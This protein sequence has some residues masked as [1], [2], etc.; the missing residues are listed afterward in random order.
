[1][2]RSRW[3]GFLDG[4]NCFDHGFFNLSRRE[5]RWVDPQQR[6]LLELVWESLETSGYRPDQLA[7]E[8]TGVF[9]GVSGDEYLH[10]LAARGEHLDP[11]AGSG[12]SLSMLANRISYLCGFQG[13]SLALDTACSSSLVAVHLAC[14]SLLNGDADTAIAGGV[15]IILT[16]GGTIVCSQA[17]MLAADG[18]C[19]TFDN[20]A[21]G[22]V[23]SE[24]A[25]VI[26]LKPLAHAR[27]D[28]DDVW[29]VIKGSAVNHDGHSK[30]GITAPNPKAQQT[31]LNEAYR[32]ANVKPETIGY[33]E[34]HGTGTSLGDPLEIQGLGGVFSRSA[35]CRGHC[36]IGS[37]K[38]NI[39]HLEPAAGI[40]GLIKCVLALR[41]KQ[42]APT[43]HFRVP[44]Q[45]VRFEQ[46]AFYINDRLREWRLPDDSHVRRPQGLAR[47]ASAAPTRIWFSKRPRSGR[48]RFGQPM[49]YRRFLRFRAQSPGASHACRAVPR[50]PGCSAGG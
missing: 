38:S 47:L 48:H 42:L 18:R 44:N 11:H 37:V 45:A 1:M 14:Q 17:G 12:N 29:A 33:L 40:A 36:A 6:L 5:A 41:Y 10:L 13:P 50:L 32:R 30:V 31:V 21:D 28:G 23:R 25:A 7:T 19:K 43:L 24:G 9:I 27:Q 3:G 35:S 8:R 20:S 4:V 46:T 26:L 39:G 16:P 22:Y 15:N 34:A 2:T 49:T